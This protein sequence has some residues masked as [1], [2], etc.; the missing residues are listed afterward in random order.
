MKIYFKGSKNMPN[1]LCQICLDKCYTEF[2]KHYSSKEAIYKA[3]F[4]ELE[5][6]NKAKSTRIHLNPLLNF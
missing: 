2:A 5:V 6:H 1:I 3:H 4:T